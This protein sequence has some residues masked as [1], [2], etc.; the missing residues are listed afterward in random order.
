MPFQKRSES[1]RPHSS[2]EERLRSALTPTIALRVFRLSSAIA[3]ILPRLRPQSL[4]PSLIFQLG[5][6]HSA[7]A[8]EIIV[9]FGF[10]KAGP[11]RAARHAFG[12]PFAT[13]Q[14]QRTLVMQVSSRAGD[15]LF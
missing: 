6:D 10:R 5:F 11:V 2:I 3:K 4:A 14:N 13:L 8:G 1:G 9:N 15:D 7:D 12:L